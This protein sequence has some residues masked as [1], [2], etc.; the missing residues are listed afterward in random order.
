MH[1]NFGS[2]K[3][4]NKEMFDSSH[5]HEPFLKVLLK[6]HHFEP[7]VSD[8]VLI[9]KNVKIKK[10]TDFRGVF[11]AEI[12]LRFKISFF[13]NFTM[14]ARTWSH[15]TKI[16]IFVTCLNFAGTGSPILLHPVSFCRR[17]I[18]SRKIA[19]NLNGDV[20]YRELLARRP[21]VLCLRVCALIYGTIWGSPIQTRF[22]EF[23]IKQWNF[24]VYV[25]IYCMQ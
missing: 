4:F 7:C 3:R 11:F 14:P 9:Q 21:W 12:W 10:S 1:N 16:T 19:L 20:N 2:I 22:I 5:F 24:I 8:F 17:V 25:T 23:D 18:F 15:Y 6:N 13:G